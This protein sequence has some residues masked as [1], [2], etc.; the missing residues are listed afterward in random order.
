MRTPLIIA[1]AVLAVGAMSSP[2]VAEKPEPG[3]SFPPET[4]EG[5]CG[6][7]ITLVELKNNTKSSFE[8]GEFGFT[9]RIRGNIVVEITSDDGRSTVLR[10]PGLA[11][12][13]GDED[14][15]TFIGTGRTLLIPFSPVDAEAQREAG[16][17]DL[18]LVIGRTE[19]TTVFSPETGE[20]VDADVTF[21]GKVID[22][23]DLLK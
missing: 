9:D 4:F 19:F 7:S 15:L 16:L 23:C 14:S 1:T 21:N 10:L 22:V 20:A 3:P 8:G 2:A 17:P 5:F 13:T 12:I 18:A 6:G 11:R